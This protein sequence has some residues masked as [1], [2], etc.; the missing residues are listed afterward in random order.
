[1]KFIFYKI[2]FIIILVLKLEK[3]QLD[4]KTTFLYS[5]IDEKIY[6]E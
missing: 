1:M 6:I 2:I 5:N 4:I 3:E